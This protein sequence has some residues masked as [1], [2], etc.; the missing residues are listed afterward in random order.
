MKTFSLKRLTYALLLSAL[1]LGATSCS[2]DDYVYPSVK[3]E[4]LTVNADSNGALTSVITDKGER[5]IVAEDLTSAKL[6]AGASKR[7]ISNYE[8]LEDNT[9]R[10]YSLTSVVNPTPL[11][12]TDKTFKDGVKSDPLTL[13]S[14]WLG[15]EYINMMLTLKMDATSKH[16]FHFVEESVGETVDGVKSVDILLYHDSSNGESYYSKRTYASLPV[17]Q[18]FEEGCDTLRVNIYYHDA[19][20][21]LEERTVDYIVNE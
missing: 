6:D 12:P 1:T 16:Y 11:P 8:T 17:K 20:N 7:V 19:D 3:L 9:V 13:S 18:Y 14:V 21:Q 5:L 15:Y 10:I 2:D 4:M